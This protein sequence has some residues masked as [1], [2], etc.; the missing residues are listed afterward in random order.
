MH[1]SRK[2]RF[3][4]SRWKP[5]MVYAVP[6]LDG[7]YCF[8]QAIAEAMPTVIDVAIFRTRTE[9]LP[10]EPP[11]LLRSDLIAFSAT[12]RQALNRGDWATLG[13]T[14][15]VVD[16]LDMPNQRLLKAGTTVGIKHADSGIFE[17]L[18]N[19]WYGLEPWNI[20]HN[21]NYYDEKLAPGVTRP[22]TAVVLSSTER[23]SHRARLLVTS[24]T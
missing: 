24:S 8:A 10:I 12:W 15:L 23:E 14:D 20:M 1:I 5:G 2:S 9:H 11:D 21:E 6:L 3:K 4:S 7:S 18:L 16:E 22:K 13:V 17:G 19:A